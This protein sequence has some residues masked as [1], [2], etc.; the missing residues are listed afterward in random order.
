MP[1]AAP[2]TTASAS[3]CTGSA[4]ATASCCHPGRRRR[5][6]SSSTAACTRRAASG[7]WTRSSPTSARRRRPARAGGRHA[8]STPTTS[9]ASAG[10]R[11][12][13]FHRRGLDA[14]GHGPGRPRGGTACAAGAS[15]SWDADGR[16][17]ARRRDRR[18]RAVLQNLATDGLLGG[19]GTRT[20]WTRSAPASAGRPKV[21]YLG[22]RATEAPP[23]CAAHRGVP[24]PPPRPRFLK[25]DPPASQRYLR[26]RGARPCPSTGSSPSR[27]NGSAAP[28]ATARLGTSGRGGATSRDEL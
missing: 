26:A 21:R 12:S 18:S 5:T 1:G 14:L 11:D 16:T 28:P 10:P 4:S 2:A 8:T 17:S 13:R 22:G 9:R 27:R 3:G 15:P 23:S 25:M 20:P 19:R 24:R 7:R 6:T